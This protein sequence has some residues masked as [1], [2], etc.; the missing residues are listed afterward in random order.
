M[1]TTVYAVVAVKNLDRAKSRLSAELTPGGRARLVLAMLAD[2]LAAVGQ[3]S[4][5]AGITVVTPDPRVADLARRHGAQVLADPVRAGAHDTDSTAGAGLLN[6]ALRH[7]A[8]AVRRS[9]GPVDLLALQPDLPALRTDDL[10][11]MLC[12]AADVPRSVV[13]DHHDTGTAALVW[14][15][16]DAPLRPQ[17]GPDSARA[18]LDDG[19]VALT[20]TWPGLRLDVDTPADLDLAVK[21]G[22][23]P[24]TREALGAIGRRREWA[25][26]RPLR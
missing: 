12:A 18:H 20:G 14:R 9:H 5:V 16:P 2:T 1:S 3:S 15:T 13:I 4:A 11:E 22:V 7:A 25:L 8:E 17:F 10:D 24:A 6:A 23:G 19:A 21:L 26:D